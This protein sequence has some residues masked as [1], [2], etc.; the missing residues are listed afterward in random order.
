MMKHPISANFL[1]WLVK[2]A[3]K[4]KLWITTITQD[5]EDFV[6]SEYWKPII[7]NSAIQILLRQ[8]PASIKS[9]DSILWL[10]E[11]EKQLLVS[12]WVGEWLFFAWNQHIWIKILA[13]PY[14]KEFIQ[15]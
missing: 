5:I 14:E 11:A 9:L 1:Y 12:A 6:K 15:T 4:Y 3:R 8:S 13:S 7:S 10:S 2:R